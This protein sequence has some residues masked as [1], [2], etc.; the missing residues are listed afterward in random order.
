MKKTLIA[1]ALFVLAVGTGQ[2]QTLTAAGATFPYPIYSKWFSQYSAAHPGVEIN[3]QSIGSGGGIKQFCSGLVDF[4]ASDMPMTDEMISQCKVKLIHLPTVLGA[5]VPVYNVPGVSSL[6]F[7]GDV[8]ADI[9]L[10][11]IGSWNDARIAKDNPGVKLPDQKIIVVHRSDGS[12]TSF[13][14]TD[15]LSKVSKE[16]ADGPGKGTSPSWPVGVGGKGNE[17]VAGLV[18]QLPGAIGYVEL[19]YALQNKITFGA[20]KNAAGN[21]ITASIPGVTE[22]AASIKTMPADF[23]VSI[24]NAPGAD[25]YPISS[26]TYLLIPLQGTDQAKRAV[27]KDLLSWIVKS[28]EGEVSALSYAPLPESV[29]QKELAAIYALK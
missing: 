17:G 8:L 2:A 26:F 7:S 12:G 13:I 10:G 14:F 15:Y 5:V 1:V 3:Y 21:W 11:K 23:R 27:L 16:W 4:G 22:A 19:I 18:R 9:Y 28:G 6:R 24:T 25:A 20:M 29:A